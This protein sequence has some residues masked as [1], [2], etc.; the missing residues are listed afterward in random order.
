LSKIDHDTLTRRELLTVLARTGLSAPILVGSA[1]MASQAPRSPTNVRVVGSAAPSTGRAVIT[2]D[3]LKF[4]GFIRIPAT[5]GSLWFSDGKLALRKVAGETRLFTFGDR[6][7]GNAVLELRVAETPN[8]N[9]ASSPTCTLV[10]NWGMVTEGRMITG[11]RPADAAYPGGLY[12]DAGR[13]A[14]W[15]SYG[16][17]YVPSQSHPT[18]GCTILNDSNG[19]WASYGPWR[20]EWNSQRTRGAFCDIPSAFSSAYTSGKSVGLMSAQSSGN[21]ASPFGAILSGIGLPDPVSTPADVASNTHWTVA[22][23][24]LILHDLQHRMARDTRYKLC[25]WKT[26]Y[27][28]RG[29]AILQPGTPVFCGPDPASQSDS[30]TSCAWIDLPDKHGLLYFGH[31]VTTPEGYVAPGDPDGFVHEWYGAPLRNDGSAPKTCCH[32]Q[33]DPFWQATGPGAHYRVPM[34]WIYNP[35]DLVATAQKKADLWSRTPTSTF[36][37]R[38]YVPSLNPRYPSGMWAG[39]VFDK[40]NRRLY[41][42]LA[43]HDEITVPPNPRPVILVFDVK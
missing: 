7:K 19:T 21:G 14:V 1:A 2:P 15:W 42:L 10:R 25:G 6:T 32:G 8:P 16:D 22:N 12:W 30:M 17:I 37:W 24:G 3:D 39:S 26:P 33:D 11:V 23:H 13:N 40:E 35:D 9:L 38:K 36:Q 5:A 29:G 31:L 27:D 28:C 20:T 18:L 4:A 34:G 43:R 41:A